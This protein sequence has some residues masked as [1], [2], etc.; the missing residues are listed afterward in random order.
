[1]A[2]V[3]T[4]QLVINGV[5]ENIDAV[6][7]L[8]KQLDALEA[9][10]KALDGKGVKVGSSGGGSRSE[11][12]EQA[13]LEDQIA[14]N[15]EKIAAARTEEYKALLMQKQ[16]LKEINN[17]QKSDVAGQRLDRGGY[18]N[19]MAGLKQELYDI[20][21]LM[22]NTDLG[23][24]KF[25]D[26]TERANQLTTKLKEIEQS[27]GVYSRSVGNYA[28][29]V[30]EGIKNAKQELRELKTELQN[31]SVKKDRGIITPEEEERLKSVTKE[32]AQLKSSV[33]D[34]GKPMDA[35][36]DTMQS[37]VAIASASKGIAAF[38]GLDGDKVE[39]SLKKLM[40]LQNAM[41]GLQTIQK[42]MQTGEG[43]GKYFSKANTA[44]DKFVAGVTKAKV[45]VNGLEKTTK[46]ATIAV[47]GFS[48]ALK[49]TGIG[50]AI[51]IGSEIINGISNMIDRFKEAKKAAKEFGEE[52]SKI[53]DNAMSEGIGASTEIDEYI[54]KIKTLSGVTTQ[55]KKIVEELNNKYGDTLGYY[56][57]I[58]EWLDTLNKKRDEYV[59]LLEAEKR[60][61]EL[62]TLKNAA[63]LNKRKAEQE[64]AQAALNYETN[65][66]ID[67][68]LEYAA[69]LE[70]E[71]QATYQASIASIQYKAQL[72][73]LNKLRRLQAQEAS[74]ATPSAKTT[75]SDSRV[76]AEEKIQELE[77][78]LMKEGLRKKLIQLDDERRKTL[79]KVK[80]TAQEK[81]RIEQLY[82]ELALKE[83]RD[84]VDK[85]QKEY[86]NL[87]KN[88]E[89][90]TIDLK[91][92][93]VNN[94]KGDVSQKMEE[95]LY[96]TSSI[97]LEFR[98]IV[99]DVTEAGGHIGEI[100]RFILDA[101]REYYE[102]ATKEQLKYNES[103]HQLSLSEA[104]YR[105]S[106]ATK[107]ADDELQVFN[108]KMQEYKDAYEAQEEFIKE[109][110]KKM[111][112]DQLKEANKRYDELVALY[113]SYYHSSEDAEKNHKEKISQINEQYDFEINKI[114]FENLKER[115][116]IYSNYYDNVIQ[117][118]DIFSDELRKKV[119]ALPDVLRNSTTGFFNINE[120][121]QNYKVLRS[122]FVKLQIA[123]DENVQDL[124]E[125]WHKGFISDEAY[126]NTYEKLVDFGRLFG[127]EI[128]NI[129]DKLANSFTE[130]WQNYDQYLQ[131]VGQATNS[132]LGS[133]SEITSNHYDKMIDEQE[134]YVDK[135][136]DLLNKQK[137]KTQEYANA[138]NDIEGELSD[139]RGD[140]R[141]QLIDQLNAEM[142]AQ[143]ASLEQEKRIEKEKEKAEHRKEQLEYDQAVARKKMDEAQ[144]LING[145]MAASMAAV[146]RWPLP[147]LPMIALATATAAAQ[148]AAVRSQYIP[149]PSTYADGGVIQGNSHRD[150]GVPVLGGRAEVEGGEFITNKVTTANN[151]DLLQFINS[152]RKR[153]DISDLIDFY[154]SGKPSKNITGIR[155]KFAD[156]GQ[157]PLLRNDISMNDRILAA[158]EDYSNKPTVVQVVDIID[159]TQKLNEVK[160]I[161]GLEV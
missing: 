157:L 123:L 136:N 94:L 130:W 5:K 21:A 107:E 23:S 54:S 50:L 124:N 35:L 56:Y 116:R 134:K 99:K 29:G 96:N 51:F 31:L 121:R 57:K 148:Y 137:E 119:T 76:K 33:E 158:I 105:L 62:R 153:V 131:L 147:A 41:Q 132:I 142:A 70:K 141:Q 22:Q 24:E 126:E 128:S 64:R 150:G 118:Y 77:M 129:N 78:K 27:Y 67:A 72:V 91:I 83:L 104:E 82:N 89:N 60:L 61:E 25:K 120:L 59:K 75:S 65:K 111:T 106:A 125:K 100:D 55:E 109:N 98:N 4:Y 9:R 20:K 88:I 117:E 93:N 160:V 122:E 143:R 159:R 151:T 145:V 14:K 34:A 92:S 58:D 138:V 73:I 86:D 16:I 12:S 1:M 19:T 80:G 63:E 161:S 28:N 44:V 15:I 112:D 155:T 43:L 26:L 36:M 101:Q 146:N 102:K 139:A 66:G 32:Y 52:L 149:K 114:E 46:T 7:A 38:F 13:K 18:A 103:V 133:L 49:A 40:A 110:G 108:D 68:S 3:K 69:A 8:N 42:Q 74:G 84:Y 53:N 127:E 154:S 140:R 71:Q 2:N 115:S 11:L 135:F 144:A 45:G 30:T 156:G 81:L 10:I 90:T 39:E 87:A 95:N 79:D 97:L 47:K 48:T 85:A 152:K 37:F 6:D 113:W 17:E